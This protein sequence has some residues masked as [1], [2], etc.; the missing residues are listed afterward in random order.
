MRVVTEEAVSRSKSARRKS[1]RLDHLKDKKEVDK[2]PMSP[3]SGATD[4]NKA[5][6]PAKP[7]DDIEEW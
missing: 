1:A 2:V 3:E 4:L 7:F 6:K 5:V